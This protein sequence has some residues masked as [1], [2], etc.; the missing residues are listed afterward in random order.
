MIKKTGFT[1]AEALLA[2]A[3]VGVIATITIPAVRD[4]SEE[5]KFVALLKKAYSTIQTATAAAEVKYGDS[6]LWGWN[7]SAATVNQK[8][9]SVMNATIYDGDAYD[10]KTLSNEKWSTVSGWIKTGDGIL[11][12]AS[13]WEQDG[14]K[15]SLIY[16]D[17]NG[18]EKPNVVGVDVHS[19]VVNQD[20]VFPMGA[21]M[22]YGNKY[23]ACTNYALKKGKM[24]WMHDAS[25]TS[26][27]SLDDP[28]E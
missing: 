28:F 25:I 7:T 2:L 16:V 24:P 23:W 5:A 26:C 4:F 21:K 22:H 11:Y 15:Y 14:K 12:T 20:G 6:T 27:D 1:L 18:P 8:Y 17:T 3:I 10:V 9:L 13:T 19:F